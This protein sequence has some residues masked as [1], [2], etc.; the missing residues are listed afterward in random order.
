MSGNG[1]VKGRLIEMTGVPEF[2]SDGAASVEIHGPNARITYFAYRTID[3]ELVRVPVAEIVLPVAVCGVGI[4]TEL[5][6]RAR[7]NGR[8]TVEDA[9]V[10]TAH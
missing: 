6:R 7:I 4:V 5:I 1:A 3:E 8:A 10:A 2:Y 9:A